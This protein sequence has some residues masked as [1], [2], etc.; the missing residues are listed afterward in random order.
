MEPFPP[1][2]GVTRANQ[3][4]TFYCDAISLCDI[5][6]IPQWYIKQQTYSSL[7]NIAIIHDII[8]C[9]SSLIFQKFAA[10]LDLNSYG[11]SEN[12]QFCYIQNKL[13]QSCAVKFA[14]NKVHSS[15]RILTN[16]LKFEVFIFNNSCW[17]K[18]KFSEIKNF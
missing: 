16:W 9:N 7:G 12:Y 10:N 5:S 17:H 13:V 3:Y 14:C 2:R 8:C 4:L 18:H 1:A 15:Q 6:D 11:G